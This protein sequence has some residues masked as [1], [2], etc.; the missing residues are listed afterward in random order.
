MPCLPCLNTL[1]R[2]QRFQAERNLAPGDEVVFCAGHSL[3]FRTES[4][5]VAEAGLVPNDR[6]N[7]ASARNERSAPQVGQVLPLGSPGYPFWST[8]AWLESRTI[9]ACLHGQESNEDQS[10]LFQNLSLAVSTPFIGPSIPSTTPPPELSPSFAVAL[11]AT[12][13]RGR[14]PSEAQR[15]LYLALMFDKRAAKS[16][17]AVSPGAFPAP[18]CEGVGLS[19]GNELMRSSR[20]L[21]WFVTLDSVQP[22][23]SPIMM[24]TL[25]LTSLLCPLARH[26]YGKGG[27]PPIPRN[28]PLLPTVQI[29]SPFQSPALRTGHEGGRGRTRPCTLA[30]RSCCS[31]HANPGIMLCPVGLTSTRGR[32]LLPGCQRE[33]PVR[34]RP[35]RS[36]HLR[37]K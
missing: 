21:A 16:I 13:R 8:P 20:I 11:A 23:Q 22:P 33:R 29:P 18:T 6:R 32:W 3:L 10:A 2:G 15:S 36:P 24:R 26:L 5:Y 37:V 9:A 35:S 28:T 12:A 14:A 17:S 25:L 4:V 31:V 19:V 7:E 1:S 30:S 34:R 27:T